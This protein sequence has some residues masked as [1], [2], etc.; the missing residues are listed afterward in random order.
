[1]KKVNFA[2]VVFSGV[3]ATAVMTMMMLVAPYM[4]MPKMNIGKMLGSMMGN[5]E[6]LGWIAHFVIGVVLAY[7]YAA[8][9]LK[10]FNSKGWLNGLIYSILPW[11]MAQLIVMPMMMTMKGMSFT[12]GLFSG[13]FIMAMGSLIGHLFYGTVLGA[14]YKE[15]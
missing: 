12:S 13:S 4:G 6:L 10:R 3:V 11:L 9:F 14:A 15:S 2:K 1:M 7:I 5:S 8:L